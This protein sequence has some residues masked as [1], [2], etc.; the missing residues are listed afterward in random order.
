VGVARRYMST[1]APAKARMRIIY[2]EP[3]EPWK[4]AATG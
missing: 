3:E 2:S 4:L 1:E